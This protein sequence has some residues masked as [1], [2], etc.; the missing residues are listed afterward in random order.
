MNCVP[1][2]GKF[3]II[4]CLAFLSSILICN[5]MI[6][7]LFWGYYIHI[8]NYILSYVKVG[9]SDISFI[10]QLIDGLFLISSKLIFE[11][12]PILSSVFKVDILIF[13]LS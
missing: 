5:N 3:N 6:N 9:L 11:F 8:F 2:S 1:I 4:L 10:S 7:I 13:L 12:S